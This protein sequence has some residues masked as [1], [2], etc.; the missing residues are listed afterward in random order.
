MFMPIGTDDT[1]RGIE[2]VT[3]MLLLSRDSKPSETEGLVLQALKD[4]SAGPGGD[5]ALVLGLVNLSVLL[6]SAIEDQTG[7][8]PQQTLRFVAEGLNER[9]RG[10]G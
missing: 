2:A 9:D 10:N 1:R 4:S 3:A 5:R 6:L 8:P 7:S